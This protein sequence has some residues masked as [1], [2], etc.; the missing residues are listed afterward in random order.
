MY[1]DKLHF[2]HC[3][4]YHF[5]KGTNALQATKAIRSVYGEDSLNERTCQK[6][7]ASF[8][9][10]DFDLNDRDRS[11]RFLRRFLKSIQSNHQQS[12]LWS[13]QCPIQ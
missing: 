7:F 11:G 12:L 1:P 6:W 8:K 2:R 3:M 13:C 4:F 10:G 9:A 5:H